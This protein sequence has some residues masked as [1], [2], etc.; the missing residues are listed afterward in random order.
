MQDHSVHCIQCEKFVGED[1]TDLP[2]HVCEQRNGASLCLECIAGSIVQGHINHFAGENYFQFTLEDYIP[3]E[4]TAIQI[5]LAWDKRIQCL[6]CLHTYI[7][8]FNPTQVQWIMEAISN[9]CLIMKTSIFHYVIEILQDKNK[10]ISML[11][12]KN[13]ELSHLVEHQR[14]LLK[15]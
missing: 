5:Y 3:P 11:K 9:E 1:K 7:P 6:E 4:Q 2:W 8:E 12:Q 15:K 10:I 14:L 13:L